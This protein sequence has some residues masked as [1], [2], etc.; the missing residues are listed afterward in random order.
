MKK[1][2]LLSAMLA[3]FFYGC[4]NSNGGGTANAQTV[5]TAVSSITIYRYENTETTG[6]AAVTCPAD[7]IPISAGGFCHIINA[8]DIF[9]LMVSGNGAI[10]GCTPGNLYPY[11]E[12][13]V[14]VLCAQIT[15]TGVVSAAVIESIAEPDVE[16]QNEVDRIRGMREALK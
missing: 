1:I 6:V 11:D 10:C 7:M 5:D 2:Y 9:A 14:Y 8:S 15:Y 4:G 13:D 16:L 12:V 3:L